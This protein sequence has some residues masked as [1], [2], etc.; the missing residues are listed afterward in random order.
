MEPLPGLRPGASSSSVRR[1]DLAIL[2]RRRPAI[3][4]RL[5]GGASKLGGW[6]R[7]H[8]YGD[9][10]F[11]V[12]RDRGAPE[13]G[14]ECPLARK[15]MR[16]P[17]P[18]PKSWHHVKTYPRAYERQSG[19]EDAA[20]RFSYELGSA[21]WTPFPQ[22]TSRSALSHHRPAHKSS[23]CS[24]HRF[25]RVRVI[26]RTSYIAGS[27]HHLDPGPRCEANPT[28]STPTKPRQNGALPA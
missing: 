12:D 21:G 2:H 15:G 5:A 26:R 20:L 6:V 8:L 23:D 28:L 4:R 1:R 24:R 13:S 22:L 16:L 10:G 11:A 17:T 7:T 14:C 25:R 18:K 27:L 19:D 3:D 9:V